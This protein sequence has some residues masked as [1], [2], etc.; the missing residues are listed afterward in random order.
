MIYCF[1]QQKKSEVPTI[2]QVAEQWC[3]AMVLDGCRAALNRWHQ[4]PGTFEKPRWT[5]AFFGSE[6]AL[7]VM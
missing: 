6:M 5:A 2:F 7:K 4:V 1:I 3:H